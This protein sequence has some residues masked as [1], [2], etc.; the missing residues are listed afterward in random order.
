MRESKWLRS[1]PW[2]TLWILS[3]LWI[4]PLGALMFYSPYSKSFLDSLLLLSPLIGGL[5]SFLPLVAAVSVGTFIDKLKPNAK[6]IALISGV[7]FLVSFAFGVLGSYLARPEFWLALGYG[8][9]LWN[10]WHFSMQ[11][12]G[13]F[14]LYRTVQGQNDALDRNIDKYYCQI[15]GLIIQPIIWLCI[16]TRWGPF[17]KYVPAGFPAEA[18]TNVTL[19]VA[20][21]LTVAYIAWELKKKN[22]SF[23]KIG[24]ALTIGIQPFAGILAYWPFHFLTY[25]ITH[26][27]VEI[28]ITGTIQTES[29]KQSKLFHSILKIAG[30]FGVCLLLIYFLETSGD[31]DGQIFEYWDRSGFENLGTESL[32]ASWTLP[33]LVSMLVLPRSFLHFYLSRQIYKSTRWTISKLRADSQ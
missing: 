7:L 8:Y 26:W 1:G 25:S 17:L 12:F 27:V 31:T 5:H 3:G 14:S 22:R 30:F 32:Y 20:T 28:G 10:T 4:F 19:T 33:T 18:I 2:D 9:L 23:Q 24:Y 29:A 6:K 11:N 16:E 15:M 21:L 13:V